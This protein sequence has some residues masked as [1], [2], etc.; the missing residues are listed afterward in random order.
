VSWFQ[1]QQLAQEVGA[2]PAAYRARIAAEERARL[3]AEIRQGRQPSNIPPSVSAA[4]NG[5]SAPPGVASDKEFFN[6]MFARRTKPP[7]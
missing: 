7:G 5:S 3:V 6:S 2:D 4:T 1:A